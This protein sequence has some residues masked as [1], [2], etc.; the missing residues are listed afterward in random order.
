MMTG[1]IFRSGYVLGT[2]VGVAG[3]EPYRGRSVEEEPL[4]EAIHGAT[5]AI[6][7]KGKDFYDARTDVKL[8]K[9]RAVGFD[10][11]GLTYYA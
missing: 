7:V 1:A 5:R 9:A 10:S 3:F 11:N 6:I 8:N 4:T 2:I